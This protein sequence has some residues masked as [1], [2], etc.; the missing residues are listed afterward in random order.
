[1]VWYGCEGDDGGYC[2]TDWEIFLAIPP[3]TGY[4][5]TANAE[6]SVYGPGSLKASGT[7]N[8]LTLIL[9]PIGAVVLLSLRRRK[10]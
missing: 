3:P 8:G 2:G 4:S 10:R 1:V 6:A 9:V 5:A 7:F